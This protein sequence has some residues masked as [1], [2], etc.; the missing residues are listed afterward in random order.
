LSGKKPGLLL[1][2]NVLHMR[3]G[4]RRMVNGL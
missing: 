1:N 3:D 2:F 4:T